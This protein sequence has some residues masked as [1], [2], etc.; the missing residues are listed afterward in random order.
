LQTVRFHDDLHSLSGN[1]AH[2]AKTGCCQEQPWPQVTDTSIA[3]LSFTHL[4]RMQPFHKSLCDTISLTR[5][6]SHLFRKPHLSRT[7]FSHTTLSH[8]TLSHTT[9]SHTTLLHTCSDL[10][11]RNVMWNAQVVQKTLSLHLSGKRVGNSRGGRPSSPYPRG[12]K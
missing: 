1:V 3:R 8:T 7:T 6:H 5:T 11:Y 9:L 2:A 4:V 10:S 12:N